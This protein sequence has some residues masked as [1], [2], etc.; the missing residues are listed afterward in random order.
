MFYIV[1]ISKYNIIIANVSSYYYYY[2][3]KLHV[4]NQLVPSLRQG[5]TVDMAPHNCKI[6]IITSSIKH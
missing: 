6:V 3:L 4:S 2:Y 5:Q 1:N